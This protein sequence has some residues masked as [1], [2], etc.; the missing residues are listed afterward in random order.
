MKKLYSKL[1]VIGVIL[2][3]IFISY[4]GT[5]KIADDKIE[6]EK[7]ILEFINRR[8]IQYDY[9]DVKQ[10]VNIDNKKYV[11]Y[12]TTDRIGFAELV[13]GPNKKYKIVYTEH[14]N[15]FLNDKVIETNG[16]KY[17]MLIGKN[18]NKEIE[19]SE[20]TLEFNEYK[21]EI[22]S[23]EYFIASSKIKDDTHSIMIDP[24]KIKLFD[25][26]GIDISNIRFEVEEQF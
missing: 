14:S 7:N 6:I 1:A 11:L 2:M 4:S 12:T 8:A 3:L 25:A 9:V 17:I 24:N 10:N 15:N 19:Y 5:Y 18:P 13:K 22:P 23:E 26:N 16:G 20:V 21:I